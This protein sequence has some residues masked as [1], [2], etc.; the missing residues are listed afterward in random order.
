MQEDRGKGIDSPCRNNDVVTNMRMWQEM[1]EATEHGQK[2]CLRAKIDMN[3][4]NKAMRDPVMFRVSLVP[5]PMTKVLTHDLA[6][7][8]ESLSTPWS[9]HVVMLVAGEVV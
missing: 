7:A 3:A 1:K 8:S 9:W 6:R 5:H 4:G 2:C